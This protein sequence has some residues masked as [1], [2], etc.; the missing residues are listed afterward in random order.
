MNNEKTGDALGEIGDG[1]QAVAKEPAPAVAVD[2]TDKP[3]YGL[4]MNWIIAALLVMFVLKGLMY[5][6]VFPR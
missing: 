6:T 3:A 2:A 1:R 4:R 5:A